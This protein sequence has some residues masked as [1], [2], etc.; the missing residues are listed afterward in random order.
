LRELH[1]VAH[2]RAGCELFGRDAE[3]FRKTPVGDAEPV[4]GIEHAQ[5]QRHVVECGVEE[6]VL[7]R[8]RSGQPGL[9]PRGQQQAQ[10]IGGQ[11]SHDLDGR[12]EIQERDKRQYGI[13]ELR[14]QRGADDDR[15]EE[16]HELSDGNPRPA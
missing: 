11:V 16:H 15:H 8:E 3:Y 10:A 6:D 12:D 5:A 2:R 14:A 7:L 9:F 4:P 1:H 13:G